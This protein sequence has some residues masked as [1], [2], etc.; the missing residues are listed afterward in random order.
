MNQAGPAD[1]PFA[2][3]AEALHAGRLRVLR[4]AV[5]I[6]PGHREPLHPD[7]NTSR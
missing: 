2:T 1:D 4:L 7:Q 3:D 5:L 6:V